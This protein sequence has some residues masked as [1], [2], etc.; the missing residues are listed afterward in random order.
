MGLTAVIPRRG[1]YRTRSH[2]SDQYPRTHIDIFS[3]GDI[4]PLSPCQSS[5]APRP[6]THIIT[7]E[8]GSDICPTGITFKYQEIAN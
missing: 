7:V 8:I 4:E 1:Q 3:N 2:I 5:C 6:S